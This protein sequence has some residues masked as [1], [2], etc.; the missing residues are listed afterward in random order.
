[1]Q[2]SNLI[3]FQSV[4]N[5]NMKQFPLYSQEHNSY[6]LFLFLQACIHKMKI[7]KLTPFK[8]PYLH[9]DQV[10]TKVQK[11]RGKKNQNFLQTSRI[12]PQ[13]SRL[14]YFGLAD[15]KA[16]FVSK[17]AT[18]TRRLI[19]IFIFYYLQKIFLFKIKYLLHDIGERFFL[20]WFIN[21]ILFLFPFNQL[22]LQ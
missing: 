14:N 4:M 20:I 18:K 17:W 8:V 22:M 19:Q 2:E 15:A 12:T 3:D 9:F 11:R 21:L 10:Q 1:M 13:Q 6:R 7:M 16:E 5:L